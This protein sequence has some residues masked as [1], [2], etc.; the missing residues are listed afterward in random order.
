MQSLCGSLWSEAVTKTISKI[1]SSAKNK[2]MGT[3]PGWQV[4]RA[5]GKNPIQIG[6][7]GAGPAGIFAARAIQR[8]LPGAEITIMGDPTNAQ[9]RTISCGTVTFDVATVFLHVGYENSIQPL[10]DEFGFHLD[11]AQNTPL[12]QISLDLGSWSIRLRRSMM[13]AYLFLHRC[14]WILLA[15]QFPSLYA[16][17]VKRY[18]TRWG[19]GQLMQSTGFLWVVTVQGYGWLS[20]VAVDRFFEWCDQALLWTMCMGDIL[21]GFQ[22]TYKIREGYGT[23]FRRAYET[24]VAKKIPN[25]QVVSVTPSRRTHGESCVAVATPD[26]QCFLFDQVVLACDFSRLRSTPLHTTLLTNRDVD[27]DVTWFGSWAFRTNRPLCNFAQNAIRVLQ[28][29]RR[30]VPTS[31]GLR[32]IDHS[33]GD[34][35]K[36][37]YWGVFYASS[38]Q[39]PLE[40][41]EQEIRQNYDD[42]TLVGLP[43]LTITTE[44]SH[45]YEYNVRPSMVSLAAGFRTSL[46][47]MQGTGGVWYTGGL[48]SHWDVDSIYEATE[49]IVE[50]LAQT[51]RCSDV[52]KHTESEI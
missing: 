10:L 5:D 48:C 40:S 1:L 22:G 18:L 35:P 23:L 29:E 20:D 30:N 36:Y 21:P 49:S 11:D 13:V 6:V 26:G 14:L 31:I 33:G 24:V 12:S 47:A 16:Q 51:I 3:T 41:L 45:V 38:S 2:W 27:I 4:Q 19:L 39:F 52:P 50:E 44:Y 37:I 34:V 8:R 7:V 42:H 17:S 32:G 15:R 9:P 25:C 28:S 43:P 46:S